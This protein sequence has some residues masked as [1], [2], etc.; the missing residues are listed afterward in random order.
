MLGRAMHG[1]TRPQPSAR[2]PAES[3]H[4]SF[5]GVGAQVVQ[6]Q[7][8][9]IGTGVVLG[10]LQD[11]IGEF[12]RRAVGVTLIN[13]RPPWA[14]CHRTRWQFRSVCIHSRAVQSVPAAWESETA[15][16]YEAP[17]A[18]RQRIPLDRASTAAF[19]MS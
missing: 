1:E 18:F 13:A 11:E 12:R 9:G 5:A 3:V 14:R 7:M 17:P 15:Y 10:N 16:P 2:L 4:Q 6:N 8:D 19:R